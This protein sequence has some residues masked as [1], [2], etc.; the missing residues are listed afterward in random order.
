MAIDDYAW[1]IW[2]GL[3]MIFVVI[4]MFTLEFT[5]L[6]LALGSVGGVVSGLFGLDWWAQLLIAGALAVV[7]LLFVR[8]PLLKALRKGEDPAKTLIDRLIG[9]HGVV[10]TDVTRVGGQ[11]RLANGETWSARTAGHH[12]LIPEGTSVLVEQIE[13]A[14]AR[15]VPEPQPSTDPAA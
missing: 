15:V 3:I 13:G 4:E 1:V 2:A 11:V 5:F 9:E 8:P 6:M 7:L 12:E 10:L 14:T